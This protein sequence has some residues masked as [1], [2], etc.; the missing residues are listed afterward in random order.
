MAR[1]GIWL[2]TENGRFLVRPYRPG[3]EEGILAS[4]RLAFG[5]E[6]PLSLWRWKYPDNPR[7]FRCLL[8][9][10]EAGQVVVHYAAQVMRLNYFGKDIL[11]LHLVDSFSHPRFRWAVGGRTGLFVRAAW[12]FLATYLEDV[13]LP[14][15][16][17]L[18]TEVPKAQFHYGFP[19]ERHYRLGLKLLSYRYHGPGLCYLLGP[20][21]DPKGGPWRHF[22][23]V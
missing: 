13:D 10:D 20:G 14:Q 15:R 21:L 9:L 8:C 22:E 19:G 3:D 17:F 1:E 11:G 6:M 5:K 16:V 2:D 12:I 18:A 4:W 23:V 7:G